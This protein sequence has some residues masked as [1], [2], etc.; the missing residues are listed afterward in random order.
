MISVQMSPTVAEKRSAAPYVIDTH[1]R[2][3]YSWNR[4]RRPV[5]RD[6]SLTSLQSLRGGGFFHGNAA[7]P[8]SEG[9]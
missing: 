4:L 1:S 9:G 2:V 6:H 5:L 3:C 7:E 8:V